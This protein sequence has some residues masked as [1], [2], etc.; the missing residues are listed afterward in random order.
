MWFVVVRDWI[1]SN[2][3]AKP[4]S[5]PLEVPIWSNAEWPSGRAFGIKNAA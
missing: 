1:T 5:E 3:D 2:L 4:K